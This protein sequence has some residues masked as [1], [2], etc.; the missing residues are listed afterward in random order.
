MPTVMSLLYTYTYNAVP[1]AEGPFH[2]FLTS[3]QISQANAA[4]WW[5][6]IYL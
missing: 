4:L 1:Y 3:R 5:S 2:T 6:A